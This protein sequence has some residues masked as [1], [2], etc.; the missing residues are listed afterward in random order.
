MCAHAGHAPQCP[1]G[2]SPQYTACP[3]AS[4]LPSRTPSQLLVCLLFDLAGGV[5]VQPAAKPR[6][7]QRHKHDLHLVPSLQTACAAFARPS[8][9]L[10]RTS[11]RLIA[12]LQL[13]RERRR[14]TSR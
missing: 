3:P 11:P 13:G 9:I 1:V 12:P 14:S 2:S 10:A 4:P 6:H 5:G 8:H 7:V